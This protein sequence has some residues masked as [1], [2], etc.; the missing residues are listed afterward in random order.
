[1]AAIVK[2][3]SLEFCNDWNVNPISAMNERRKSFDQGVVA[4]P[5][6]QYEL[7]LLAFSRSDGVLKQLGSK[8]V[9]SIEE[10]QV[11]STRDFHADV[12][13]DSGIALACEHRD[14]RIPFGHVAQY[15]DRGIRRSI[16]DGEYLEI[17]HRLLLETFYAFAD[18][19]LGVEDRYDHR[20]HGGR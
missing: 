8:E 18:V 6:E 9:I 3:T 10:Q 15:S 1:M 4:P 14:A 13:G 17:A 2:N 5:T 11:L 12:A 19:A 20:Y 7:R 16:V